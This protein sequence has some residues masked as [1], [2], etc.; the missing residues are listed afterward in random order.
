VESADA[1]G[2]PLLDQV[3]GTQGKVSLSDQRLEHSEMWM[4]L[5]D[6]ALRLPVPPVDLVLTVTNAV[7]AGGRPL[8]DGTVPARLA[9]AAVRVT[10][11]RPLGSRPAGLEPLPGAAPETRAA[12]ER[13]GAANLQRIN[14]FVLATLETTATGTRFS[15]ALEL[16]AKVPW[17]KVVIR[18]SA[19]TAT[20]WAL[21]AITLPARP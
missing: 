20:E 16:P 15:C 21:G 8:I 4:L 2:F 13:I 9:G 3:D 1:H 18:A 7:S 5:G 10:L 19:E 17:Q 12:R 11:E 14:N 6:P